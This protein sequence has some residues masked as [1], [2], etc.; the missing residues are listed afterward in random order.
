[1]V[2]VSQEHL[3]ARRQ[4]ILMAA[5][6]CFSRNGYQKTTMHDVAEEAGLSAGSLYNYFESKGAIIEALGEVSARKMMRLIDCLRGAGSLAEALERYGGRVAETLS[7]AGGRELARLNVVLW[8]EALSS[9]ELERRLIRADRSVLEHITELVEEDR[10]QG[11]VPANSDSRTMA[12]AVVT[13]VTGLVARTALDAEFDAGRHWESLG[14]KLI[15]E[16]MWK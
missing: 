11:N 9:R 14:A 3:D 10:R 2:K 1:M 7:A 8:A 6:A 13:Y 15:G 5:L 4:Q 16:A 12:E